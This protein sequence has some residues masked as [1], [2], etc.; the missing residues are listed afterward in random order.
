M[1]PAPA[2]KPTQPRRP[3]PS[4]QTIRRVLPGV[5]LSLAVAGISILIA[6]P[7]TTISP[8]I[9]A[10]VIGVLLGN[11]VPLPEAIEPGHK[12]AA[13]TFL[14]IGIVLLGLQLVVGDI[15]S[16]GAG[17]IAVVVA[18]VALGILGTVVMGRL[19]GVEKH[20][21]L[22]VACGFS[23]CGAAAVA[24][25]SG[26]IDPEDEHERTT[27]TAVALVVLFGT[28]MIVALPTSAALL[29]WDAHASGLWAGASIHEV[30]Q[31]VAAGGIIGGGALSGAVIVKLA[32]VLMLAP[33][34]AALNLQHRRE[35]AARGTSSTMPPLIPL[36]VVGFLVMVAVRS[37]LPLPTGLL[38]GA[39]LVQTIL[40]AAAMFALGHGVKIK[41]LLRTGGRPLALAALATILVALVGL[42]GVALAA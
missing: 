16:L 14:R 32:R 6:Q 25:A 26:V 40:L 30:A 8:L 9:V 12:V 31:V 11:L 18:V 2:G 28:I 27:V 7:L 21:T 19:L 10:I 42:L 5:L 4:L 20:L 38:D 23:I 24:A 17:M 36:F 41:A 3:A 35:L 33:V 29:G 1:R 34:M 13:K 37:L 15:L 39:K 22:L